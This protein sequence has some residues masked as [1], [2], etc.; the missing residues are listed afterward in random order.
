MSWHDYCGPTFYYDRLQRRLI[1]E[2]HEN[3]L[4][5]KALEWFIGR[6]NRA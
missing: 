4:I 5:V 3:L 1:D 2:W 6:G